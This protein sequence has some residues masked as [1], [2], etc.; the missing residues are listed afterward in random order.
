MTT[1]KP[2]D[3]AEVLL[4]A[5]PYIRRFA[6]KTVVI[7][8]GGHAMTD[9]ALK[10]AF[11]RDIVLLKYVGI[12]PVVVHGGGPQID[13]MLSD[14][15][16]S[17]TFVRGMRVTDANT[18]RVVE[19][20]LAGE[21]NGQ[22]VSMINLAGGKAVGFSGKDGNLIVAR[23]ANS[24][25]GDLGQVG[26]V[27]GVN[28]ELVQA[29]QQQDFIPVIAPVAASPKGESLNI[30]ADIAAGKIAE[31]LEAEKLLLLTDV[32]GIKDANGELIRTLSTSEARRLIA[33]GVVNKGMIPKVECCLEALRGGVKKV[34]VIDGRVRHAVLLELFTDQ[35]VGTEVRR[36]S[37]SDV[38]VKRAANAR[39]EQ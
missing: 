36:D 37:P 28:P 24:E 34:H 6:G 17:S 16:I 30:N 33:E 3:Q 12:H 4:E 5:L 15:N 21:I 26:E 7:K 32:E 1:A 25:N 11:A 22:I 35:G 10:Q 2:I 27:I 23:R 29:L 13:K 14:L 20:V 8:Y 18:M 38:T 39:S 31:A 9:D 19:M